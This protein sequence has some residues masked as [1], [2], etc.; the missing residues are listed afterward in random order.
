MIR[1]LM[2][3]R[4]P[5]IAPRNMTAQNSRLIVDLPLK[6]RTTPWA[7]VDSTYF[8]NFLLSFL[9]ICSPQES[10]TSFFCSMSHKG[11]GLV[12]MHFPCT[13]M[14]TV[15]NKLTKPYV[16]KPCSQILNLFSTGGFFSLQQHNFDRFMFSYSLR[17]SW[18]SKLSPINTET[19]YRIILNSALQVTLSGRLS[20]GVHIFISA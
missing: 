11:V 4:H 17:Y 5:A 10:S 1:L 9:H 13:A 3:Y 20:Y 12:A 18:K 6:M 15:L 19:G 14:N 7:V 8:V 16:C 2:L